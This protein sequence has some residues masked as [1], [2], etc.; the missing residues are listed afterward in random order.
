MRWGS[1]AALATT[2]GRSCMYRLDVELVK[3]GFVQSRQ[4]AKDVIAGGFV[5]VDGVVAKKAA[6]LVAANA[7]IVV[8]ANQNDRYVSRAGFKLEHALKAFN[9][10]VAAK[11]CLDV[12]ASTG[13]FSDCLLQ[14]GA[15]LVYAL[16]VGSAQLAEK[17]CTDDRVV[18]MANTNIRAITAD[19]FDRTIDIICIDL[20]FISQALVLPTIA[21]LCSAQTVVISLV[22]P[23]FEVGKKAIGKGVVKDAKLHRAVLQRFVKQAADNQLTVRNITFSSIKGNRGNIEFIALMA[24][25]DGDIKVWRDAEILE[26]VKRCHQTMK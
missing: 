6:Q 7:D 26:I 17:L 22:K 21:T 15:Q 24:L 3:R 1:V 14:R 9:V 20:S 2:C 12:G 10:D 11:I 19:D 18:N 8:L 23:Q 25:A 16:D 13:G 4:R 5:S